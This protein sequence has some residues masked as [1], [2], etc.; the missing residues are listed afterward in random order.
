MPAPS[1]TNVSP[2]KDSTTV[3]T[4]RTCRQRS[5]ALLFIDF[6]ALC[7]APSSPERRHCATGPKERDNSILNLRNPCRRSEFFERCVRASMRVLS[8]SVP[9]RLA[10]LQHVLDA[11]DSL[12]LAAEAHE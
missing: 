5:E 8:N 7:T 11:L 4:E 6:H 3:T 10:F 2:L 1:A 12:P 9:Q